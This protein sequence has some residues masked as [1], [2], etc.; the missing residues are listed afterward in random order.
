MGKT[1]IRK[2]VM[3]TGGAGY[4]GSCLVRHLLINRYDVV[5]LDNLLQGGDGVLCFLGYPGYEFIKGDIRDKSDVKKALIGVDYVVHLAAIVGEPAC[6]KYPEEAKTINLEGTRTIFNAAKSNGVKRFVF[7]STCS[8]YGIQESDV[9]ANENTFLNPV[10]LYAKTKIEME[11]FLMNNV[12]D[13]IFYTILRPSTVHGPSP[14]MRFDLIVNHFVKDAVLNGKLEIYGGNLWRPFMWVGDAARAVEK[15]L[16]ADESIVKNQVFNVGN[17]DT[18][19][20]KYEIAEI[21]KNNYLPDLKVEFGGEDQDLRSYRVDFS[22]IEKHLNYK[23]A[24]TLDD[25]IGELIILVDKKVAT[26]LDSPK[27]RNH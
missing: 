23:L 2:K 7:F 15:V 27:Y 17:T 8:S 24:K 1:S 12:G 13:N 25:A 9:M 5:V 22:K 11:Q 21:I 26:D 4:S 3:V 6:N 10:S 18:N 16:S 19:F 20:R 14:R